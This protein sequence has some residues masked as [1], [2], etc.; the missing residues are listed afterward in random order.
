VLAHEL[1]RRH[2]REKLGF[3][4]YKFRLPDWK[5]EEYADCISGSSSYPENVGLEMIRQD[6]TDPSESCRY[7]T[8]RMTVKDILDEESVDFDRLLLDERDFDFWFEKYLKKLNA[9]P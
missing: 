3:F 9:L 4:D 2:L 7:F 8:Y 1:V 5:N 6:K